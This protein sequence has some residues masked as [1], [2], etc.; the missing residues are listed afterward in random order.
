MLTVGNLLSNIA[1]GQSSIPVRMIFKGLNAIYDDI[2]RGIKV[3]KAE[4]MNEGVLIY[5]VIPSEDMK[6]EYDVCFWFSTKTTVNK[7]V[8][9][10]VYS[11]S[12]GFG[13]TSAYIFNKKKSLLWPDKYPS[14]M[15]RKAPKERNPYGTVGF[16]KH[17]YAGLKHIYKDNL[18][19]YIKA[20]DPD[21]KVQVMD[22]E[23]KLKS[24]RR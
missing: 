9:F 3:P 13:F 14:I 22:F 2:K 15:L 24:L 20:S 21:A 7:N 8:K 5:M 16:D 18:Y 11:N 1:K 6:K 12:P 4:Y 23:E 17:V 10:K 19:N